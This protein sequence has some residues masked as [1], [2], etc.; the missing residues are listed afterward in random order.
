MKSFGEMLPD[1]QTYVY[2]YIYLETVYSEV[3][4]T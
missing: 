2:T 4:G 1:F 3:F